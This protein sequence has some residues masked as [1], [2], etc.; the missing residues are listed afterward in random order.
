MGYGR[1]DFELDAH[2]GIKPP[3]YDFSLG[4]TI[5]NGMDYLKDNGWMGSVKELGN[6]AGA[7]EPGIFDYG[8]GAW[9]IF[10]G[11]QT[12]GMKEDALEES[13]KESAFARAT[14]KANLAAN[15]MN[16][17]QNMNNQQSAFGALNYALHGQAE[18]QDHLSMYNRNDKLVRTDGS[19]YDPITM[20]GDKP[21]AQ[22]APAAAPIAGNG[23]YAGAR[24]AGVSN[25]TKKP[26]S[27]GTSAFATVAQ[28]TNL[29]APKKLA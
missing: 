8:K 7:Y 16:M 26:R 28:P 9:D 4:K 19:T 27:P 23:G 18:D 14:T 5:G 2:G 20:P 3:E 17:Y 29:T 15:K 12:L 13:K 6:G 1:N 24:V 21:T 22:T 10:A 25:V 11:W